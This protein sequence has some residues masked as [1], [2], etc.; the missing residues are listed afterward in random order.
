MRAPL[1]TNT[2]CSLCSASTRRSTTVDRP[3]LQLAIKQKPEAGGYQAALR[4]FIEKMA[5][6][7]MRKPP[8][9]VCPTASLL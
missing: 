2:H 7:V 1:L 8:F 5:S 9:N 4:P 6:E 3:N